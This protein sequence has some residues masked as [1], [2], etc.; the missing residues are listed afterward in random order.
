VRSE[1]VVIRSEHRAHVGVRHRLEILLGDKRD[2]LVPSSPQAPA[3]RG[4]STPMH[5]T[6]TINREGIDAILA[7]S[8]TL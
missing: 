8:T 7:H 6:T 4:S 3:G 2:N 5:N 1:V